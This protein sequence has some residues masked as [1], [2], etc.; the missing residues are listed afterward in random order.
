MLELF[1]CLII[2]ISTLLMP[3][4]SRW[5]ESNFSVIGNCSPRQPFFVLWGLSTGIFFYVLLNRLTAQTAALTHGPVYSIKS[6]QPV[7][8]LHSAKSPKTIFRLLPDISIFLL[9]LSVFLPY[10]PESRPVLSVLHTLCAFSASVGLFADLV[11]LAYILQKHS[12]TYRPHFYV[13][14][15]VPPICLILFFAAGRIINSAME[16]FFTIFCSFYCLC[17]H[18]S[19]SLKTSS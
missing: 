1:A 3:G 6:P 13:L 8:F 10:L 19:L 15:I 7:K 18:R 17:L 11:L 14:G 16:I 4:T 12:R 9:V 2:P 5:L